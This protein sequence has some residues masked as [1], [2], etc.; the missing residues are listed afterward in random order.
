MKKN[1][2]NEKGQRCSLTH[3]SKGSFLSRLGT[4][5]RLNV[6]IPLEFPCQNL[7]LSVLVLRVGP[8]R[9]E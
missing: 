9:A 3:G 2:D 8:L 7:Q 1:E 6:C 4:C 5:Y